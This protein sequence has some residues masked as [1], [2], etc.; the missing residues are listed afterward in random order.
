MLDD[1]DGAEGCVRFSTR[2]RLRSASSPREQRCSWFN[3]KR[4]AQ[5]STA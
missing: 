3:A 1:D 4:P 5:P 2:R